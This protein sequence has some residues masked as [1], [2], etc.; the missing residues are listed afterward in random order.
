[1]TT[2]LLA[3]GGEVFPEGVL[4]SGGLWQKA[5]IAG[6]TTDTV[7]VSP[8]I[9]PN[10][11]PSL[12]GA[13]LEPAECVVP[14][15]PSGCLCRDLLED[16]SAWR[17]VL[18]FARQGSVSLDFQVFSSEV[19]RVAERLR[20]EGVEVTGDMPSCSPATVAFWNTKVGSHALFGGV[21]ELASARPAATISTY[22]AAISIAAT[23]GQSNGF[24]LKP[25]YG[26]GGAGIQVLSRTGSWESSRG[27]VKAKLSVGTGEEEPYLLEVMVGEVGRNQS[28]TADFAVPSSGEVRFLGVAEQILPDGVSYSGCQSS[29]DLVDPGVREKALRL[30]R[31]LATALQRRGYAGMVNADFIVTPESAV[32]IAEFNLR[33]SAPLDQ[34]LLARRFYGEDWA[35]RCSFRC[36][37]DVPLPAE[38]LEFAD[39]MRHAESVLPRG[40]ETLVVPLTL[41]T[42]QSG[43][44]RAG[45]VA[46]APSLDE[47][48]AALT[49]LRE[50]V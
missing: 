18:A 27:T 31:V 30:G 33:H 6:G 48:D 10:L 19:P 46:F 12:D 13:W 29:P 35:S 9:P 4:V 47:A 34:F 14:S 17:R 43:S 37:E 21:S 7:L 44:G 15:A 32:Y 45:Y 36:E 28:L 23:A 24:V 5:V 42:D 20:A 11:S 38:H 1:M 26:L 3:N 39:L 49:A 41:N 2:V 50:A 8:S 22:D 16:E 40:R 25:N